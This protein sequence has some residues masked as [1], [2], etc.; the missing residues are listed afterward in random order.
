MLD[1]QRERGGHACQRT[2]ERKRGWTFRHLC[3]PYG[4]AVTRTAFRTGARRTGQGP[5][6]QPASV[7]RS[8]HRS[9]WIRQAP[10][11]PRC[12]SCR[13]PVPRRANGVPRARTGQHRRDGFPGPDRLPYGQGPFRQSRQVPA[14]VDAC[15]RRSGATGSNVTVSARIREGPGATIT[16]SIRTRPEMGVARHS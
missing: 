4:A 14:Q 13:C 10:S 5:P 15:A 8:S 1:C 2:S 7:T 9:H 3:P 16:G 6:E 11:G 12:G